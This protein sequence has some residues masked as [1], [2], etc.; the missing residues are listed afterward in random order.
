MYNLSETAK[1]EAV[2]DLEKLEKAGYLLRPTF[3]FSVGVTHEGHVM[4]PDI[5]LVKKEDANSILND[6]YSR[7]SMFGWNRW[8]MG[9]GT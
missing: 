7:Y 1:Q 8:I 3:R 9:T 4:I 2:N 6:I 5:P